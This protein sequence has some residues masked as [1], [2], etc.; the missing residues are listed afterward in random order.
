MELAAIY[1]VKIGDDKGFERYVA[2]LKPYY[3]DF[4]YVGIVDISLGSMR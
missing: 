2:Q 3:N 4:K 1:S